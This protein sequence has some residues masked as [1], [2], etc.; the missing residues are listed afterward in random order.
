MA[1]KIFAALLSLMLVFSIFA[2]A[3][4]I[5]GNSFAAR[6]NAEPGSDWAIPTNPAIPTDPA[7]PNDPAIPDD[8]KEPT[9]EDGIIVSADEHF[10][11]C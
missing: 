2:V 7:V 8:G 11:G 10:C 1:K 3:S 6:A 5:D 4:A 9:L